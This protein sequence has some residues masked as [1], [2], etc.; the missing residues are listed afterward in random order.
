[1]SAALFPVLASWSAGSRKIEVFPD[2][3][4]GASDKYFDKPVGGRELAQEDIE[5]LF[6]EMAPRLRAFLR[7]RNTPP[8]LVDDVLQETF[9]QVVVD[10]LR[11]LERR[12]RVFSYLVGIAVRVRIKLM[13]NQYREILASDPHDLELAEP[14][15]GDLA[16]GVVD[17]L[18][19]REMVDALSSDVR[20]AVLLRADGFEMREIAVRLGVP[21]NKVRS[22]LEQFRGALHHATAPPP[23]A[24]ES[25][26][27]ED[28]T[29]LADPERDWGA[30][31][32]NPQP[33]GP[34]ASIVERIYRAVELLPER[35][36]EVMVRSLFWRLKPREIAEDLGIT[37]NSA[38]VNQHHGYTSLTAT[39]GMS[40]QQLQDIVR[41]LGPVNNAAPAA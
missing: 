13:R 4:F 6:R 41:P 28:T 12:D 21:V 7:T 40:K 19:I 8:E 10:R 35:Q 25:A 31:L 23:E 33:A 5:R 15:D 26:V 14:V 32:V 37:A 1:M 27:P 18:A 20:D 22:L 34:A 3:Y 17:K 9:L 36:R 38:R 11:R 16:G 39:L 24:A 2:T 30:A 29:W